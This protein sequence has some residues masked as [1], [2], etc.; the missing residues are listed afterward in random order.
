M[1][2]LASGQGA[3]DPG[4]RDAPVAF[5]HLCRR[6][7]VGPQG[8]RQGR[9]RGGQG[10]EVA[11]DGVVAEQWPATAFSVL[12]AVHACLGDSAGPLADGDGADGGGVGDGTEFAAA[13]VQGQDPPGAV[14]AALSAGGSGGDL[15][16][17]CPRGIAQARHRRQKHPHAHRRCRVLD[18]GTGSHMWTC[19]GS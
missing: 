9:L 19:C 17:R 5:T 1:Q 3:G 8:R 12:Q 15:R 16:Q 6:G 11:D 4:G 7:S 14:C 18:H 13:V 10:D 2:D